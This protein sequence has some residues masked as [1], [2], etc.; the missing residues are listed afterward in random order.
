MPD[1]VL[2]ILLNSETQLYCSRGSYRSVLVNTY[3]SPNLVPIPETEPT[4]NDASRD[5]TIKTND[6]IST[7]LATIA[8]GMSYVAYRA[9]RHFAV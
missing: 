2:F 8:A 3:I 4:W 1:I 5:H 7:I 9:I 6:C